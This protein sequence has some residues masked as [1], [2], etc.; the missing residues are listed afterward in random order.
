MF[1]NPWDKPG[2]DGDPFAWVK[3]GMAGE[4]ANRYDTLWRHSQRTGGPFEGVDVRNMTVDEVLAFND[5]PAGT[6][7]AAGFRR[8]RGGC[9]GRQGRSPVL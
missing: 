8:D 6:G 7:R 9:P 2:F 5:P 1:A 4:S 3:S